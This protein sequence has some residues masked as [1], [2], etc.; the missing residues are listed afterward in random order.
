L[1]KAVKQ[2]NNL[3]NSRRKMPEFKQKYKFLQ[4]KSFFHW[5]FSE[6]GVILFG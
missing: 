5:E 1:I 6:S 3:R 2:K 4:K